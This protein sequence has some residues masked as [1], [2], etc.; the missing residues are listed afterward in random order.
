MSASTTNRKLLI[1]F[2]FLYPR[3]CMLLLFIP[4]FYTA[5]SKH[6]V[7]R[8]GSGKPELDRESSQR[9]SQQVNKCSE[10]K[11]G[12]FRVEVKVRKEQTTECT[13]VRRG[14]RAY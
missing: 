5:T 14:Q 4:K 10:V 6:K 9:L 2:S 3:D 8:R 7:L 11:Y 13:G 1:Y 12:V